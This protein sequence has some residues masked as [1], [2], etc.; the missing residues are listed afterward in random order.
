[1]VKVYAEA[2][3]CSSNFAD[4]EIALGL[5]KKVGFDIVDS[6]EKSDLNIIFTCAVKLPTLQ[7]MIFRIKELTKLKKPLI[8]AGCMP[9]TDLEKIEKINPQACLIAPDQIEKIVDV[10][11]AALERKKLSYLEDLKKP[12]INLPKFRKNPVI[13]ITQVGRGCLSNCAYCVEP[14]RGKLFSYPLEGIIEDIKAALKQGCKEIWLTSLDNGCYGFDLKT[15]LAELLKEVCKI[16][17]KFFVRVGMANPLHIKKILK[18][19][20]ETYKNEKIFKFLHLPIQSGS[21]K[22]LK[23]MKRGYKVK[24]F[25]EIV[26]KFRKKF[27]N[28]SLATDIIVGFPYE[29]D[30]DFKKTLQLIE[31]VKPDVVNISKFGARTG[32]EAVNMKQLDVKIVNERSKIISELVKKITLEKNKAWIGWKGEVLIDEIIGNEFVGR[33]FAYKPVVVKT[34]EN[35]FGKFVNVEITDIT[36]NSLIAKC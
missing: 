32:T 35:I 33:N 9:K 25:I 15:N 26:E 3:G 29:N 8:I 12:K 1:M 20:I 34:K 21:D 28:I 27:P 24:D 36:S 22:I 18:E 14:Y 6:V 17:G 2:Y 4:Y 10:A 19:L 13:G 23:L 5:L 7:R 16:E 11:K 31:K 30:S